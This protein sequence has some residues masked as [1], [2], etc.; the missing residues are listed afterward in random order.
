MINDEIY[1]STFVAFEIESADTVK[2]R[3]MVILNHFEESC[4]HWLMTLICQIK[5]KKKKLF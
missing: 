1:K 2:D 3:N 5:K 4:T